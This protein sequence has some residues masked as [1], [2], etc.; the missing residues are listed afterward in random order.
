MEVGLLPDL[1]S[2]WVLGQVLPQWARLC[3]RQD[4][5]SQRALAQADF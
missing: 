4:R 2:A 5:Q 3:V 1:P